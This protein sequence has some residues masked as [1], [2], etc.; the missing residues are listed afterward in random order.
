[1]DGKFVKPE[2]ILNSR[3]QNELEFAKPEWIQIREARMNSNLQSQN[4]FEFANSKELQPESILT[5][6]SQNEFEFANSLQ[7]SICGL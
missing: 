3:S 6:R 2:S 7:K 4:E 1:M 5:S